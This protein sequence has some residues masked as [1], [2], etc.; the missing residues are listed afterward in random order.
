M[1][2][3][4]L[5][6]NQAS[7]SEEDT[8]TEYFRQS[9][10]GFWHWFNNVWALIPPT[11]DVTTV[12]IVTKVRELVPSI[13]SLVLEVEGEGDFAGYGPKKNYDWLKSGWFQDATSN[14]KKV[15]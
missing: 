5:L 12:Q 7:K 6:V 15:G 8:I 14:E 3:F 11:D 1:K 4:V 13:F 2:R 10:Y 9:G